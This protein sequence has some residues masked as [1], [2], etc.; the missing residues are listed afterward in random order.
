MADGYLFD[1]NIL[2]LLVRGGAPGR[3]L[4]RRYALPAALGRSAISAVT[5]GEILALTRRFAWGPDKT[6]AVL[7]L[8][9][10]LLVVDIN[11]PDIYSAYAD[12][13]H[14]TVTSG[15]ALGKNDLWIAAT[16]RATGL[17]LL[18]TDKDFDPLV[19]AWL[20]REWVDQA[21]SE[22]P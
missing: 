2:V 10:Q 15:R 16:A 5:V 8:L 19:P 11:D 18:T 13:D 17:T 22:N 4:E 6:K 14:A 1:T 12:I 3:H 7:A 20:A 9:G 21:L